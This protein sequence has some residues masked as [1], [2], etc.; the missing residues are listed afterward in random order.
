VRPIKL[1]KKEWGVAVIGLC[2][3]LIS[4][5]PNDPYIFVPL[6]LVSW[7]T[8]IYLAS[9][10]EGKPWRRITFVCGV[11]LALGF[12]A[13]RNLGHQLEKRFPGGFVEF[14]V[15]TRGSATAGH[16][17]IKTLTSYNL[18]VTWGN[19]TIS[20][21]TPTHLTLQLQNVRI[22]RTETTPDGTRPAGTIQ[23]N[24]EAIWQIDRGSKLVYI[25][26]GMAFWGYALGGYLIS[27]TDDELEVAIGLQK[28]KS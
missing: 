11:S 25:N 21:S 20:E 2:V 19:A 10:H 13:Y 26:N 23:I 3:A 28:T 24:G 27:D 22:T 18:D 8:F 7:L 16:T 12:I 17:P 9:H 5:R 4:I 1:S 15:L 6:L 14:A